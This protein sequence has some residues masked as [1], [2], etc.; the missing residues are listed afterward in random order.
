MLSAAR[1]GLRFS[2]RG[3][4]GPLRRAFTL[5]E[6]LLVLMLLALLGAVLVGG[7]ASLLKAAEE[8]DPEAALLS[9]L[10]KARAQAVETG[11][12]LEIVPLP[13]DSGFLWGRDGVE[14]L[15]VRP[16]QRVRLLRPEMA[17]AFLIGGQLEERP[18]ERMRFYPD[19]SADPV[20]LEVRRG[21]QRR[22]YAIDPWTA[23]PLPEGGARR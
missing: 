21:E 23:A 12:I 2:R 8:Q 20:R 16:G 17:A 7:A 11:Q 14:T 15:P 13:D 9:L 22:V 6:I 19:G 3:K 1:T 4:R 10:Q 18:V 5:L